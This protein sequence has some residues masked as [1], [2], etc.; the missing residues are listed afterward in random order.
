[1]GFFTE[2]QKVFSIP[3][4]GGYQLQL[5]KVVRDSD[6]FED[7]LKWL[8]ELVVSSRNVEIRRKK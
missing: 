3:L 8:E 2:T 6:N 4:P 7:C 5:N 1:M